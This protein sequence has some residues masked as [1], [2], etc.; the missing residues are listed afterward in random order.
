MENVV[1]AN[2]QAVSK[3]LKALDSAFGSIKSTFLK[4]GFNLY[5]FD[6]TGAFAK[7]GDREY[8]SIADFAK[9]RYGLSKATTYSYLAVVKRFGKLN[10]KTNEID[11]LLDE[12]SAYSSTALITM[13][14]MTDEQLK[15]CRPD[16]KIKQIKA[17]Y[18]DADLLESKGD[19]ENA[20]D[21]QTGADLKEFKPEKKSNAVELLRIENIEDFR[22]RQKEIFSVIEK[23]LTQENDIPYHVNIVMT[24]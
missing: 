14:G 6:D 18:N 9:D 2:K 23:S 17:I 1:I 4:I 5:W 15:R 22:K 7:I 13:S 19:D 24:W 11:S 3:H 8:N 10:S 20:S 16:M 21:N 12:Y